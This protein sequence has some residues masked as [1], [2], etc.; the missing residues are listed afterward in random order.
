MTEEQELSFEAA[1]REMEAAV[2]KLEEG[3]LKLDESI[4]LYERG[5]RLARR[6]Q[7]ALDTAELRVEQ[8]GL[9]EP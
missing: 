5:T 8:L 3:N 4:A 7:A 2:R 9:S 1:Y 6:C